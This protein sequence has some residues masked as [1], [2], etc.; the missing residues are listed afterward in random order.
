VL[1]KI[2]SVT[3]NPATD[4]PTKP[5]R[6]LDVSIYKDPFEDFK[7]KLSKRL[8]REQAGEDETSR[9]NRAKE[10]RERDRTT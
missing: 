5:I 3:P 6:I 9:R 2:E 8:A 10:E 1:N 4:K 7:T